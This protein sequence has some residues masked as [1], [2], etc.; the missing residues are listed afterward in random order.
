MKISIFN[1]LGQLISF[2]EKNNIVSG[3]HSYIFNASGYP[4]GVYFVNV[5]FIGESGY[6]NSVTKKLMFM[7]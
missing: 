3:N 1:F 2:E 5:S 6:C 7:K 4:S